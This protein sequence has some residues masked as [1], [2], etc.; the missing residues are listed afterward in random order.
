MRNVRHMRATQR[1][2][3]P[4]PQMTRTSSWPA[5]LHFLLTDLDFP[6][7]LERNAQRRGVWTVIWAMKQ[8]SGQNTVSWIFVTASFIQA[9]SKKAC[10]LKINQTVQGRCMTRAK[11]NI[12]KSSADLLRINICFQIPSVKVSR[13]SFYLQMG[14]LQCKKRRQSSVHKP[15]HKR[16]ER[17]N[18]FFPFAAIS[19]VDTLSKIQRDRE[20]TL[21]STSNV[22]PR[23]NKRWRSGRTGSQVHRQYT[24]EWKA[25]LPSQCCQLPQKREG[26]GSHRDTARRGSGYRFVPDRFVRYGVLELLQDRASRK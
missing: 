3:Y 25:S 9:L 10:A 4:V 26:S 13:H 5:W 15:L 2:S 23:S 7:K 6:G 11:L 19:L 14:N 18:T 24:L 16:Q 22:V 1:G 12:R 21:I 17:Y 8:A 20:M